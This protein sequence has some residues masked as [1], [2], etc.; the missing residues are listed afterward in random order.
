MMSMETTMENQNKLKVNYTH[1]VTVSMKRS[2]SQPQAR[3]F[4]HKVAVLFYEY[5]SRH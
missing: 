5:L 3:V 4:S 1:L 2:N